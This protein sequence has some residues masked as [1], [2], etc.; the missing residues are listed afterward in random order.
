M[1]E[2]NPS[3]QLQSRDTD[4]LLSRRLD[5]RFLL[6]NPQLGSV[7]YVGAKNTE[8]HTAL[9]RFSQTV[10]AV[11]PGAYPHPDLEEEFDLL[12][13]SEGG[14]KSIESWFCTLRVGGQVYWEV[15]RTFGAKGAW[16]HVQSY[17]SRLMTLGTADCAV[18]WHRPDFGNC[19]EIIPLNSPRVVGQAIDRARTGRMGWFK[20]FAGWLMLRSHLLYFSV[21]CFSV[22]GTRIE[23]AGRVASEA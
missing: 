6:P 22:V 8:M 4:I 12:V 1:T 18:N 16:T 9:V 14:W 11:A 20:H 3:N 19:K 10:R 7:L 15:Q 17:V 13:I 23:Q 2:P 5:W 21:P